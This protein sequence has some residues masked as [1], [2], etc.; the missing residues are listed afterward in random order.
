MLPATEAEVLEELDGGF[1]GEEREQLRLTARKNLYFLSV[2]VLRRPHVNLETHGD[3]CRFIQSESKT[4]RMGL[5]PRAHL[6]STL[7]TVDDSLRLGLDQPDHNRILIAGETATL[8]QGFLGQIKGHIE[9]NKVLRG[10]FPELIPERFSGPGVEWSQDRATLQRNTTLDAPTWR[11]IG[12][13]GAIVGAHF[14]RIKC[15]DL[16]GF[17][18]SRSPAAMAFTKAWVD[19]IEPLLVSHHED[20]IDFIGTRWSRNDLYAHIMEAYKEGLAVYT[21]SAIEGGQIIFPGLHTWEEYERIQRVNPAQWAAQYD[22]NP[23]STLNSDFSINSV[24]GYRFTD[25][26][27]GVRLDTG[28][29]WELDQLDRVLTADPN[30]GSLVAP[31]AAAISVQGVSPDDEV[32]VLDSWSGRVSPS[33]FVDQIYKL[34][35]RWRVRV[36]GIEKAGQQNTAHYFQM[37]AE[38][39]NYTVRVEEVTPRGR[40]KEERIRAALEPLIRSHLL[41]IN[42]SQTTLRSQLSEFPNCVLWDEVD[43][44]AYGPE[45]WRRPP[46]QET[47]KR[48]LGAVQKLLALRN[49]LTGY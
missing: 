43:A 23:L 33:D 14:T 35:K 5:M 6:K 20:I 46:K 44:L 29:E 38:T 45:I 36:V 3:F 7:A 39:E 27:Q 47:V 2:G 12:V 49:P 11:A 17:E 15:D 18:A 22:N 32:A 42:P 1:S 8:S 40:A 9:R 21:R 28:K 4:R 34:A 26:G 48:R 37:K 24:L 25:D 30:S 16:I 41:F 10:L 31:D 13:G 19:N